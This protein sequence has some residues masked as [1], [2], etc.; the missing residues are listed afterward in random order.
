MAVITVTTGD[1]NGPGKAVSFEEALAKAAARPGT[2]IIRFAKNVD[3]VQVEDPFGISAAGG[4]VIIDGDRNGDGISDVVFTGS[5]ENRH[6]TI[7]KGATV[8]IQNVDFVGGKD[9]VAWAGYAG[10]G[11]SGT[12][13][14]VTQEPNGYDGAKGG[15]GGNGT[16]G[17]NG[18]AAEDAAGSILNQGDLTL[19]RVGFG[20]NEARGGGGGYGGWGGWGGDADGGDGRKSAD[21]PSYPP[22]GNRDADDNWIAEVQANP[23]AFVYS[24]DGGDGGTGGRGGNGGKGGEGGGAGGAILNDTG[25][26]LRLQD[27][28]FGGRLSSGL[29]TAGNE[30]NG[31]GGGAGGGGGQGGSARGGQGTDSVSDWTQV[32]TH[33]FWDISIQGAVRV[34]ETWISSA[35]GTGGDAGIPGVGGKGG[36]GGLG[37]DAG[38]VLNLGTLSGIAAFSGGDTANDASEGAAGSAGIGRENGFGSGGL[39]GDERLLTWR[40]YNGEGIFGYI[41]DQNRAAYQDWLVQFEDVQSAYNFVDS[42]GIRTGTTADNGK[43]ALRVKSEDGLP[44]VVGD[45]TNTIHDNGASTAKTA[46]SLVYVHGGGTVKEGDTLAFTIARIGEVSGSATVSWRLIGSDGNPVSAADFDGKLK[47][48]VTFNAIDF[49]GPADTN[50]LKFEKSNAKRV[51]IGVVADGIAEQA[52][53]WTVEMTG[54]SGG[55]VR[56]GTSTISGTIKGSGGDTVDD[57]LTGTKKADK[58]TG[59]GRA[60]DMSGK[61]GNDTMKG[62]G[63]QDDMDGGTGRDKMEGGGG[64]DKIAGGGGNDTLKG[65]AGRDTLLG[66]SGNDLLDGGRG[67]DAMTGGRGADVFKFGK[68]FGKDKIR[69]F[70]A[71]NGREDIDLSGVSQIRNWKDLKANH[72]EA[73]G[74]DVVIDQGKNSITL[75]D[76]SLGDLD[77]SDFIF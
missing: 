47:G 26:V 39:G 8:T 20:Q 31:G 9:T 22:A 35:A 61:G 43:S 50:A 56:L 60:D 25:A 67:N 17:G 24:G 42:G 12:D 48:K 74:D 27:V 68:G 36:N 58:L 13:I 18:D 38:T 72:M 73:S 37:G 5:G 6:L 32:E 15:T 33:V 34:I 69:D 63:G 55:S 70:D 28:A 44:G 19:V 46:S 29:V 65:Q 66:G 41:S 21:K 76:V 64:N 77:R 14:E 16:K 71:S 62:R 52:E 3:S 75:L 45:A 7:E 59:T 4:P 10:G 2:D 30:A 23:D 1:V 54:V 51:E 57:G 11:T 53:G 40:E 49:S